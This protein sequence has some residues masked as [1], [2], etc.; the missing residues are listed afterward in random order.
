MGKRCEE[1]FVEALVSEAPNEA[2][3]KRVLSRLAGSDVVPVNPLV[4]R[5]L[6]DRCAGELGAV[7][8]DAHGGASAH[9]DDGIK[10]S[11]DTRA[12]ER[13]IPWAALTTGLSMLL[14]SNL[15]RDRCVDCADTLHNV[16]SDIFVRPRSHA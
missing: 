16:K 12:R 1:R 5:P 15:S 7:V 9:G 3:G 13:S 2:F 6:Q 11:C 14:Q 8:G 10:L 4:L